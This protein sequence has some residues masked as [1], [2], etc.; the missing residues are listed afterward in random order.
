[1]GMRLFRALVADDSEL[2]R[3]FLRKVLAKHFP[4]MLIAEAGNGDHALALDAELSPQLVFMDIKLP[5]RSGLD[6]T[7]QLK[8]ANPGVLI[9]L[10]TQ[11]DT[12]EYRAAAREC[13]ADHVVVLDES[14]E[15]A[16]VT[17]VET[18]L[19]GRLPVARKDGADPPHVP[20][21]LVPKLP[22]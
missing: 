10:V 15:S 17:M 9:Y 19:L 8:S 5:D 2:F 11:H 14:S 18:T 12:P 4:F 6:L 13:G 7:R 3:S 21:K 20:A 16:I 1:M 22:E